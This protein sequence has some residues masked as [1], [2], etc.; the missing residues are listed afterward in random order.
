[1]FPKFKKQEL[2]E[3]MLEA[4]EEQEQP[5]PVP[6]PSQAQRSQEQ[7]PEQKKEGL[8]LAPQDI[9]GM[10][11]YHLSRGYQLLQTLE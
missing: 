5:V 10:A 1:M 2:P 11:M 3:H 4:V 7:K 9:F 8:K 6:Q